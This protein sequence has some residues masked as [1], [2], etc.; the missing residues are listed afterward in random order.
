MDRE[1]HV[2]HR[3]AEFRKHRASG[4]TGHFEE[5]LAGQRIAVRVQS[6]GRQPEQT[7]PVTDPFPVS[8][9]CSA[10]PTI[11]PAR[12]YSRAYMP[13]I[14]AVSP[15]MSAHPLP[16]A[17][18][19]PRNHRRGDVGIQLSHREVIQEEERQ[20]ALHRDIVD[21]M[22]DQVLAHRVVPSVRKAIFSLVP[23]PSA[24]LTSTGLANIRRAGTTAPKEPISV[25]TPRVNVSSRELLIERQR[26][27]L[28]QY[29]RPHRGS[30]PVCV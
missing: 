22:I 1:Q 30:G 12:S 29:P 28:R 8:I 27:R 23:T 19:D 6:G 20:R 11:K 7:S 10:A 17:A 2:R 21:T 4:C 9:G 13:G 26:G 5:E 16:A 14:S 18:G 3:R 24:E 15:P 25:S